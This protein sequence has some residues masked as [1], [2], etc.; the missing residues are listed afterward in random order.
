MA[1]AGGVKVPNV[2]P[3]RPNVD[4]ENR[5]KNLPHQP[6]NT[7]S[8]QKALSE[9]I[10]ESEF[11]EEGADEIY[12]EIVRGKS[13]LGLRALDGYVPTTLTDLEECFP[14]DRFLALD[15]ETTGLSPACGS[16]SPSCGCVSG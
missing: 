13:R 15:V 9:V 1:G 7:A 4:P 12:F 8:T 10:S 3:S 2:D 6:F 16:P 5:P 11:F 14:R